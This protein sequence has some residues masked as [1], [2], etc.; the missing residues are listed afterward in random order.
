[1]KFGKRF[2]FLLFV[3]SICLSTFVV[4][5]GAYIKQVRHAQ[6][7]LDDALEFYNS[8]QCGKPTN[9]MRKQAACHEA[10]DATLM[11]PY[12]VAAQESAAR[13]GLESWLIFIGRTFFESVLFSVF[14]LVCWFVFQ[15]TKTARSQIYKVTQPLIPVK[16][17]PKK[18][19]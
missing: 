11:D 10:L 18:N 8:N 9:N 12:W 1:M 14:L 6:H 5:M 13:Y 19:E 7:E 16:G 17:D 2:F 4:E 3:G 15:K